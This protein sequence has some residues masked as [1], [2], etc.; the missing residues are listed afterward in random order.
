M[1][2]L[3]KNPRNVIRLIVLILIGIL[4][5]PNSLLASANKSSDSIISYVYNCECYV[6]SHLNTDSSRKEINQTIRLDSKGR[7][8]AILNNKFKTEMSGK[9]VYFYNDKNQI[10][11]EW[12]QPNYANE[13]VVVRTF[14]QYNRFDSILSK[15]TLTLEKRL[16]KNRDRDDDVLSEEDYETYKTWDTSHYWI[17]KYDRNRRLVKREAFQLN[18]DQDMYL[19]SYYPNGKLKELTSS[20]KRRGVIYLE[21]YSYSGDTTYLER[22]WYEDGKPRSGDK[23]FRTTHYIL[24]YSE[25][26]IKQRLGYTKDDG[27]LFVDQNYFYDDTKRVIKEVEITFNGRQRV[28][29]NYYYPSECKGN[30]QDSII[31]S[32]P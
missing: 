25:G 13:D 21:K 23:Y 2:H 11:D 10:I 18:S 7:V 31:F 3:F 1:L 15:V 20:S 5:F 28:T 9:I 6:Y 22:V 30:Y 19:Y 8:V 14:Y 26:V 16:K 17:Y 27:K 4:H 32:K 24:I 29:V 12:R